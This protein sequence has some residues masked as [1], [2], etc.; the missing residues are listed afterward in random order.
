MKEE[1]SSLDIRFFVNELKNLVGGFIQ[2]IYQEGKKVRIEIY[3]ADKGA[4]EIFYEPNKIFI[5][6]YR[7]KASEHPDAFGMT[8]RKHL[9]SQRILDIRQHGFDRIIEIETENNV[10]IFEIFS[11]G[12]VI[13]CDKYKNIIMP[14]E[15][16]LWKDRQIIPKKP[17]NYPPPVCD[18]F[19]MNIDS[20]K[21][22]IVNSKKSI[23]RTL[24]TDMSLSGLYA[25]EVCLRAGI[26]K[27]ALGTQISEDD[28]NKLYNALHSLILHFEPNIVIEND[29]M[30]DVVP[31][32]MKLYSNKN[33]KKYTMFTTALD[34]Y[35]TKKEIATEE[36]ETRKRKDEAIAAIQR[37]LEEQ[38]AMLEKYKR[39]ETEAR[40]KAEAIYRH[41]DLIKNIIDGL[42]RARAGGMKWVDIK[43]KIMSEN[44]PEAH[45]IKEIHEKDGIVVVE[46]E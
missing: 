11:K 34:E 26:D 2:K 17:Y 21:T 35:F 22:F 41:F 29:K 33:T 31:F 18:P 32:E 38:K 43:E 6:E 9:L 1:M 19:G 5:T 3:I 14:L 7:R 23:V 36:A 4:F 8:L 46:V 27:N 40:L 24:A 28:L 10:L 20:F 25:E 44:T 16:Q 13:L 30:I 39:F 12:N 45:A 37:R 42:N 15:V